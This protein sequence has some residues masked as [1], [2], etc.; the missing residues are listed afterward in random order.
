[1]TGGVH[2][3]AID[4]LSEMGLFEGT[5]CGEDSFCPADE[6][7]RSTMAVWLVRALETAEPPEVE[8]SRFADVDED[9]WWKHYVER[10]AELKVTAGCRLQPLR[11]CPSRAVSRAEMATFLVRAFDLEPAHAAGFTDTK[12]NTHENNIN[13]L[14]AAGI[15]AGCR[16]DP[17][18]YCPS[19]AVSRAEMATFLHRAL[20]LDEP[21][22]EPGSP[23]WVR[24]SSESVSAV[25]DGES[26]QVTI[27]FARP[28]QG[29]GSE[30]IEVVNGEVTILTGSGSGYQ[31][32]VKSAAPGTV[33]IRIPGGA[34]Q[35]GHGN[36]SDQSPPLAR[37]AIADGSAPGTGM[38]TWDRDAVLAA[39]EAE[40]DRVEPDAGFT[41]DI[42]DC[43]AGTTSQSY[44]DSVVQ[45]VNWYRRMAGLS[46]VTED[47][48][49][50]ATAQRKALIMLAQGDLSHMPSPDWACFTEIDFQGENL[51]LGVA[52]IG[53][54]DGY[55]QDPG[56]HN[57]AVGHRQQVLSPFVIQ[58]GTG[59]VFAR[60]GTYRAAN[61]M[62][63]SYGFDLVPDVREERGFVAWPPSGFV[64]PE[65]VW[66]RWSFAR[67]QIT[68]K[69]TQE[70]NIIYTRRFLSGPDFSE[71]VV[72]VSDD[73]G[74]VE[75][76]IIHR[77]DLLVWAVHGDTDSARLPE[78]SDGDHCYTVKISG[79]QLDGT[80]QTPYEYAVCVIDTTSRQQ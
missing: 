5:L 13:A 4:A 59:D 37:V 17:L 76:R 68:T 42:D 51:A 27:E 23:L 63:L 53:S 47:R 58:I 30:D 21:S 16:R 34:A 24:L 69:V 71:A 25:R 67:Q 50:S 78:P 31:A 54:V 29:F 12:N 45:R 48:A 62:H 57:L 10:L 60:A 2:K 32:T 64:P 80:T 46:T 15:T 33:V 65:T 39:Y 77:D 40:F 9:A 79:V 70:G 1:M 61:V 56:D 52:G 3:P 26:F 20:N 66:G 44:R 38:D 6:I 75:A 74:P 72:S 14:A 55:M 43:T 11:Y 35:D 73:D 7:K 8:T 28:V 22:T 49:L 18:Q 19:R 36:R 41:G